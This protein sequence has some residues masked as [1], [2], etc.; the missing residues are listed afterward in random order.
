M[1]ENFEE[2]VLKKQK[3]HKTNIT[4]YLSIDIID[5]LESLAK[6]LKTSRNCLFEEAV[7]D[8][9]K[10]KGRLIAA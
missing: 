8:L 5:E 9:L 3:V 10:K 2:Q 4:G 1:N 7:L 6:D